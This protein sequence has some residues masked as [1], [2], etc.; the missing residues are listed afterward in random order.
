[1]SR[2]TSR[3][4]DVNPPAPDD[5]NPDQ[6]ISLLDLNLADKLVL[7]LILAQGWTDSHHESTAPWHGTFAGAL[8]ISFHLM[9]MGMNLALLGYPIYSGD[10]SWL[11][12]NLLA[13]MV[14]G[15][16]ALLYGIIHLLT[17]SNDTLRA[18]KLSEEEHR[19][20]WWRGIFLILSPF[21]PL[22]FSFI[23]LLGFSGEYWQIW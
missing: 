23:W 12:D 11:S 9:F 8:I 19:R 5:S 22:A 16:L 20:Y 4:E 21:I 13:V 10:M 3:P 7:A 1:M 17:S 2:P 14:V 6:T 15:G 18:V